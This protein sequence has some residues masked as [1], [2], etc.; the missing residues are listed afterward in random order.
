MEDWRHTTMRYTGNIGFTLI[1][2]LVVIAIIAILAAILFPVFATAREKARQISCTSNEKQIGLGVLQY[3]QDYDETYPYSLSQGSQPFADW[4]YAIYPYMKNGNQAIH[5]GGVFSC[6]SFP[7]SNFGNQYHM[8]YDLFPDYGGTPST[9][10]VVD[11]PASKIMLIEGGQANNL[12]GHPYF[13][14]D[15]YAWADSESSPAP[16]WQPHIDKSLVNGDCD[17]TTQWQWV[18]CDMLPRYRHNL[19]TNCLFLD[20]HVKSKRRG[21]INWYTDIHLDNVSD[22]GGGGAAAY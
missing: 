20:G 6:P 2:L 5:G 7:T 9:V 19:M 22:D 15:E 8:R 13:A 10:A 21:Q 4:S 17:S 12:W 3:I 14:T 11:T 16:N 1:E 18:G